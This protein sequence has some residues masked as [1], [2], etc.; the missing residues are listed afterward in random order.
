MIEHSNSDIQS[1]IYQC[2]WCGEDN[3]TF[4]DPSQGDRQNY[5]E[6]CQI[7]CRPNILHINWNKDAQKYVIRSEQE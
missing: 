1:T 7:C 3:E 6:D 4:I 5:T 2:A